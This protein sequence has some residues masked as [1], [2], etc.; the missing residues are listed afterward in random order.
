MILDIFFGTVIVIPMAIGMLGYPW[1]VWKWLDQRYLNRRGI[2]IWPQV[3][4][5]LV[6]L[7]PFVITLAL[8]GLLT[9]VLEIGPSSADWQRVR[10]AHPRGIP[11]QAFPMAFGMLLGLFAFA[12]YADKLT[13]H[14]PLFNQLD[15][16][17]PASQA[18]R[19]QP[20]QLHPLESYA[21]TMF[22]GPRARYQGAVALQQIPA[23]AASPKHVQAQF[24][25][26]FLDSQLLIIVK[27]TTNLAQLRPRDIKYVTGTAFAAEDEDCL[28]S[29]RS[30]ARAPLVRLTG[31]QL[32]NYLSDE[33]ELLI[34]QPELMLLLQPSDLNTARRVM[35]GSHVD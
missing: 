25:Q 28:R 7:V 19:T 9:S 5:V 8:F 30:E 2:G 23:F 26:Q 33:A 17:K 18:L 6:A 1:A 27:R 13:R 34:Q 21:K 15:N 14:L 24:Y 3:G 35:E 29:F 31:R 10:E 20:D 11:P 32:L 16:S 4:A 22:L 12:R